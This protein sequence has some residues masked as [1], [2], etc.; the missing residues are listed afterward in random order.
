MGAGARLQLREEVA[1]VTLD[2]LLGEEETL[3]DLA[4]HEA[5]RDQLK[6][7]DLPHR[8]LLLELAERALER[9]DLGGRA[10]AAPGRNRLE[11]AGMAGVAVEKLFAPCCVHGRCIGA[12]SNPL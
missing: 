3:A 2:R 12:A 6:D 8:R 10:A 11:T 4:V 1:D 7:L 9:N 5:V